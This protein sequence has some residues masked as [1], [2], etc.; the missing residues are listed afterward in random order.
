MDDRLSIDVVDEVHEALLEFV[1]RGNPDMAQDRA[2]H[3]GEEALDQIE[4]GTV[5]RCEGEGKAP[6]GLRR[7]PSRGLARDVGGM[8]VE[9]DLDRGV[10]RIGGVEELEK[11]DEFPA[12]MALSDQGVDLTGQQID[13]G[14]QGQRAVALVFVIAHHSWAAAGQWRQIRRPRPAPGQA[15]AD[16]LD[17]RLLVTGDDGP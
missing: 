2:C 3:L 5:G 12:A 14:H 16:R 17:A 8:V 11:L 10:G 9:D 6:R 4:P 13:A 15:C 7:Q 1:F